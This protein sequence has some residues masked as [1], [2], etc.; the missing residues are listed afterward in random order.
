MALV[1][2]S[3]VQQMFPDL[4]NVS[5]IGQGGQKIVFSADHPQ[6]G[7]IALKLIDDAAM[8]ERARREIDIVTSGQ[9]MNVPRIFSSGMI[10]R[11][12]DPF[13]YLYEE[14]VAGKTL[15]DILNT[16]GAFV[17]D[18]ALFAL[19]SLLRAAVEMERRQLV[20]RD[21]KPENVIRDGTGEL[22]LL[23]FGIARD[24]GQTSLTDTA[25]IIGPHS[26]GYSAPE[27]IRNVKRDIDSRCDLFSIGVV[28]YELI[29]G[30]NPFRAGARNVFEVVQR[31]EQFHPPLLSLPG[32]VGPD[33]ARFI[34]SL[35]GKYP[36]RR[37]RSARVALDI[38]Q[39][40]SAKL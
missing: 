8:D 14:F 31:V 12:R 20:H 32:T 39:S 18:E 1:D 33:M 2:V 24:L 29:E 4:Q 26:L 3:A 34:S 7:R 40:L 10:T 22:W 19:Q 35:M 16:N 36:T 17:V 11:G 37:P 15:R 25:A 21:I 13:V 27:Q 30:I 6:F 23:D 28:T 5:V 38:F 9:L